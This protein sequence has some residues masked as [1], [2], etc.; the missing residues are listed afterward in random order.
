MLTGIPVIPDC[1]SKGGESKVVGTQG[2]YADTDT[3]IVFSIPK[4]NSIGGEET[5]RLKSWL[6]DPR[7][8]RKENMGILV[9]TLMV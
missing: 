1:E 3:S 9:S 7:L 5:R 6:Q 2:I 8:E 4:L